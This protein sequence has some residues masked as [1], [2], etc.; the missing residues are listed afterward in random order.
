M[1]VGG[2]LTALGVLL[3]GRCCLRA[4]GDAMEEN[5]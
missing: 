4:F 5:E 2:L 3:S 1:L